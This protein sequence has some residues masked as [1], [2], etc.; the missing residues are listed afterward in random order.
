LFRGEDGQEDAAARSTQEDEAAELPGTPKS[1][2][3][4]FGALEL[5][6]EF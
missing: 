5:T 6:R 2:E 4:L 1:E 3:V